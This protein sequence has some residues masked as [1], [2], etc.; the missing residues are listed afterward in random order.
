MGGEEEDSVGGGEDTEVGDG[1]AAVA[2]P[3]DFLTFPCR[4]K[5]RYLLNL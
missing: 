2:F 5:K 1:N 3:S 4:S